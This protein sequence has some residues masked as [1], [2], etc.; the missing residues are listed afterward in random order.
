M[1]LPI[2]FNVKEF[3]KNYLRDFKQLKSKNPSFKIIDYYKC[4]SDTYFNIHAELNEISYTND[5][6]IDYIFETFHQEESFQNFINDKFFDTII[7]KFKKAK[8]KRYDYVVTPKIVKEIIIEN[9]ELIGGIIN[10]VVQEIQEFIT[11]EIYK[12]EFLDTNKKTSQEK[13]YSNPQKLALLHELGFFELPIFKNLSEA[14]INEI[15][16]ILLNANPKE[17]VYKNRLNLKSKSPNYQTDKY[18]A[19][20]YLEDMKK[21]ISNAD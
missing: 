16:G 7:E 17:F 9:I 10:Y 4:I 1:K 21:L 14:K 18:T 3:Q 20:Q 11:N 8:L 19:Y 15:T 12:I 13:S 2:Y 5:D 6:L